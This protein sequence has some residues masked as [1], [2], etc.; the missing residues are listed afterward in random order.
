MS[1]SWLDLLVGLFVIGGA[2]RGYGR[3]LIREGMAFG[4][5]AVGLILA[6]E[7]SPEVA[8]FVKPF[9]GGGRVLD[10]LAYL[11]VLVAVLGAATL[12]TVLALRLVRAFFAGWVDRFGG[13][14]FGACQGAVV[15][16]LVLILMIKF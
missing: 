5:L 13:A 10:V 4:G 16:A 7:W 14:L 9:V 1:F 2:V 6:T 12:L 11:L 3:G 8:G 15:A